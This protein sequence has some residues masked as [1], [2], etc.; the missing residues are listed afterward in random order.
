MAIR[1]LLSGQRY[2]DHLV[3][4]AEK[5]VEAFARKLKTC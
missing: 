4:L 1:K 5:L 3:H 2:A